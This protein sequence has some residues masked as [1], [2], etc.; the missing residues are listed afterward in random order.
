MSEINYDVLNENK[1]KI[2]IAQQLLQPLYTAESG[3]MYPERLPPDDT[4]RV[5]LDLTT[6]PLAVYQTN[7]ELLSKEEFA[8]I[9]RNGFGGSDSSVL[10][11]VNPYTSLQ[12]LII[13]KASTTLSEE[14]LETG[15]QVAVLKG[16]D[17]EPLIIDKFEQIMQM[18]TVKPTD[19]YVYKEWEYL[20]M[21]FDGVT[22]TPEQY[23]PVEIKVVTKKGERHYDPFKAFYAEREGFRAL[24]QNYALANNSIETKAAQ[25]G[26]PA[27][28]YTQLQDEMMALNAPF[29]YLC[30]LWESTW[31]VRIYFMHKDI[32]VWNAIK[33]QGFKAWEMVEQLRAK[34]NKKQILQ[35][36]IIMDQ[37]TRQYEVRELLKDEV[38]PNAFAPKEKQEY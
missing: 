28:Y 4:A 17:L 36:S 31:T 15:N 5:E 12:E 27:Y 1:E 13:Q 6:T 25:Y 20:K 14:E 30:T 29:G 18:K 23:I 21:N 16:N 38:N 19:M 3:L 10:L 22:G 7:M 26:I 8:L 2:S 35:Q 33:I 34:E 37:D 11:G 24:P 9:R 32:D